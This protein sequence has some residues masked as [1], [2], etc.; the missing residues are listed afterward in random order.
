V[1][2]PA[3]RKVRLHSANE[4]FPNS[5][6]ALDL[7]MGSNGPRFSMVQCFHERGD[8]FFGADSIDALEE[9]ATAFS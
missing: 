6:F 2:K 3:V 5:G 1:F 7:G 9:V 4:D 8:G